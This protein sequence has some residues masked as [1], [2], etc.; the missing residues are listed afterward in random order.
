MG[1]AH[2]RLTD[3]G[4]QIGSARSRGRPGMTLG[5]AFHGDG[6]AADHGRASSGGGSGLERR[7]GNELGGKKFQGESSAPW[8]D[9]MPPEH[10]EDG[11]RASPARTS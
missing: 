10:V 2:E 4:T 3:V 8:V 1:T 5:A 11:P 9:E 7:L 6:G